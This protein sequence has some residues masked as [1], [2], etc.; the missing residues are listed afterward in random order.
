MALIGGHQAGDIGHIDDHNAIDNALAN[1][2]TDHT[3]IFTTLAGKG[4]AQVDS[5]ESAESTTS[6]AY[7]NLA[8]A[9]PAVTVTLTSGQLCLVLL[10]C[11]VWHS[12]PNGQYGFAGF[13]VSGAASQAAADTDAARLQIKT[14]LDDLATSRSAVY[15]APTA[16]T[17]TFTMKYR[18]SS[19][20]SS[21]FTHRR[22]VVVPL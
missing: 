4:A 13:A 19:A 8:T 15:I 2:T 9:G 7:T 22:I 21:V 1:N 20:D 18:C 12:S 5:V 16:G 14:E 17:F 3:N 11:G 10:S 6:T